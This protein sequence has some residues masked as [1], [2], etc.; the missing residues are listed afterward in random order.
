MK[1]IQVTPDFDCRGDIEVIG[2]TRYF[3]V[4]NKSREPLSSLM[5]GLAFVPTN[6]AC[7]STYAEHHILEVKVSPGKTCQAYTWPIGTVDEALIKRR[8]CI[9][10][11]DVKLA[12]G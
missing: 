2:C 9:K 6:S 3:Q 12:D 8:V 11:L 7:P 4:A 10:V 1:D 5:I